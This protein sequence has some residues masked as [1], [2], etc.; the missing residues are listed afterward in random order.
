MM[1]I[2]IAHLDRCKTLEA[3]IQ[4]KLEMITEL[5]DNGTLILNADDKIIQEINLSKFK[6]T[7]IYF[8][9]YHA[10]DFRASN[11]KYGENGMNFI[12]SF[13]KNKYPIFV[14]GYGEHQ[15]YNA[16]AAI[17]AVHQIGVNIEEAAKGLLNHENLPHHNQL[18][19]GINGCL[20]LD[21]TWK[22]NPTA[23]EA[24]F[25]TLNAIAN[26]KE[27]VALIGQIYGLGSYTSP[28]ASIVGAMIAKEG[29]DILI[30]VGT[31]AEEIAKEAMLKGLAGKIYVFP[32]IKD[33]YPFMKKILDENII[34]LAKC[35]MYDTPFKNLLKKLI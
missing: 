17:A 6:G 15:V 21:D 31:T 13:G 1:N 10:S 32:N 9:I 11:I 2:G 12:L 18:V 30:T 23:L 28:S 22:L 33:V 29:V 25:K 4:A 3:Y 14:P 8:G 27:R 34:L 7:L 19:A 26:G 35:Y 24:A 20:I 16:L 5:E